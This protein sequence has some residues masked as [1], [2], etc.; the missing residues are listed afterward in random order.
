[1]VARGW[2]SKCNELGAEADVRIEAQEVGIMSRISKV[3]ALG[4]LAAAT[5][6][7]QGLGPGGG[8]CGACANCWAGGF[9]SASLTEFRGQIAAVQLTPGMG[10]PSVTVQSGGETKVV[11][12][13]SMRYLMMQ[14]FNPKVDEEIVVKA[15]QANG[16]YFAA[17]VILPA[18]NK[19]VEFRDA[20][21]RPVWRRGPRW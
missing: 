2:A 20:T 15:F 7:A 10:M 4:L 11:Y 21:G 19:T 17:S 12:L 8:W 3:A 5:I 1:M 9:P 16:Q 18:A 13:G 14:G 6:F